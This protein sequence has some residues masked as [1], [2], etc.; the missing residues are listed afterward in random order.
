M[1]AVDEL[2]STKSEPLL[3][4]K[5][6]LLAFVT[7]GLFK[8]P[9]LPLSESKPVEAALI[10]FVAFVVS[11]NGS[12]GTLSNPIT[13]TAINIASS[14]STGTSYFQVADPNS[15]NLTPLTAN[16]TNGSVYVIGT[17]N[18][19]INGGS[20]NNSGSSNALSTDGSVIGTDKTRALFYP[21][22][23]LMLS[24]LGCMPAAALNPATTPGVYIV[25]TKINQPFYFENDP[26]A[27]ILGVPGTVFSP[28]SNNSVGEPN[29]RES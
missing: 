13:T 18:I 11:I 29:K 7:I 5:A 1:R 9:I 23:S 4:L 6:R 15:V 22:N 8:L 17:S 21:L 24:A 10:E 26:K 12:V 2:S 25:C 27:L 28:S 3:E 16:S 20:S 19:T 14:A